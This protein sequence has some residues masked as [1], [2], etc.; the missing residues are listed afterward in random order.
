MGLLLINGRS[1]RRCFRYCYPA[2]NPRWSQSAWRYCYQR[3]LCRSPYWCRLAWAHSRSRLCQD[4]LQYPTFRQ[5]WLRQVLVDP[6]V[7]VV[8][9]GPVVR[10]ARVAR[11]VQL[12]RAPRRRRS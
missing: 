11:V 10:V 3:H 8:L 1:H 2:R 4:F 5:Y 12:L 6:A 9:A 7:R